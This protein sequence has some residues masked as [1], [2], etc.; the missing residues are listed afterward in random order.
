MYTP[1]LRTIL[2]CLE[3]IL[4]KHVKLRRRVKWLWHF[5]K[6]AAI[7]CNVNIIIILCKM[8][9]FKRCGFFECIL[10]KESWKLIFFA[11][12]NVME[13]KRLKQYKPY[14][15][16]SNWM[17]DWWRALCVWTYFWWVMLCVGYRWGGGCW[18]LDEGHTVV[19]WIQMRRGMLAAQ[20]RSYC[21]VLD[22]DEEG[23]VGSSMKVILLCVGY[24][25]GGGCWQ[26]NEGHTVVCW[27]QMRRGMLAAQ[28]RSY[29]CVL[30]TDEEGDVGSSMKVI[31]LCVG[32]R[33]GGDVGSSMKVI[34]LCVGYRW[35]GGCWQLNEGHTVVCW[36]QMRRGMLAAQWR[37]YC[38]VLDTDE[39]GDVGSSM[40]VILLCVGYRWGGGCWQLNEGHTVV[41]WIQMRRGMLAAQWRSYCCVLDTDE[42]GDVG[43]S[44]KVIL[45]CVGYR[46]GGDVGS[47]MKVILLC[48]GYRWGG[49]C[50]QLNE[51]HTVVCWIQMRRGMLAAQWRSYCCVLDTDE[52]GGCWQL[53]EGHTVVCWIQMRRGMLAAQWRS[54]CCVLDTDEEGDVGSSMKVILLCVG[55]RWGGG[56][57]QLNE[58]HTVVCW[59]QMRG[60]CW[61]LN[62]GHTVVCWIQMRG[63]VGSSMKVI[64]L[65]VGYR[66][67]GGCWQL[68]EGHTVVCW[69]QMRGG[70]CW[71]LNEGHTVVCWIQMR[72]GDVGSS[73]KVI[74]LCV[75]YRW[76]GDVG[77]SMKVILL[78]VGYRWGGGCWQ[79]NEGH[80]VVCWVQMRG[81]GCWQL[82][83]GH[84]VV[85]WIQM[86]RG[87]C[88][89]L[90]EGHT[91]VCWIQMRRGMLAAQ[92]R[93]YWIHTSPNYQTVST[94]SS[95]IR[96]VA[97]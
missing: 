19:C 33:W 21:C 27:I 7:T 42:E 83:E 71:Q 82:N 52:G 46:W 49:G 66:W 87:G 40:K 32:Y 97:R 61:Q 75:G 1:D 23:D 88:W 60:G 39:E 10:F 65:C 74:L 95:L 30:D 70:G 89:Q 16:N 5:R 73:M 17:Y 77:S 15:R 11:S 34:L 4:V 84:T 6:V 67:G 90:N 48:V 94:E 91:V 24:R 3:F 92:W 93:S 85:C 31:L 57:W 80:T 45:L 36:I 58:G 47:S 26:L 8:L 78:C 28:W 25:W 53:N 63:D 54:Y 38:C 81:G 62:E 12:R 79:L 96:Y 64:L 55:Y 69:I 18:Q 41:C 29:C 59:I 51:G 68:N 76:G 13:F 14:S 37:S 44:M 20:W 35:G 72:G 22:T 56:C 86:R 43:S 9:F 2:G 50:W